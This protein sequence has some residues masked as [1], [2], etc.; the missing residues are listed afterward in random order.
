M[1]QDIQQQIDQL[2]TLVEE[3]QRGKVGPRGP[4]GDISS[5]THNAAE[6]TR[7][8][9]ADALAKIDVVASDLG[10]LVADATAEF[11]S[12]IAEARTE[13]RQSNDSAKSEM[14]ERIKRSEE[15]FRTYIQDEVAA[16]VIS[17]LKEYYVLDEEC[18]VLDSQQRPRS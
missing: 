15:R 10:K 9:L 14:Q 8:E 3:L 4:A 11:R 13:L 2:H 18:R 1:A 5:A 7:K 16:I 6:A 17:V 12:V